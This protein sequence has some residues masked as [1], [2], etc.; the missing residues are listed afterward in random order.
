M[1]LT[2]P[3]GS[4]QTGDLI[5][6]AAAVGD[7]VNNALA[8]PTEG[9]YADVIGA[10]I[11]S[12]DTNDVNLN[13]F[14]KFHNGTDTTATFAAVGGTNASNVAVCMVFRGVAT[15]A[16]GGPFSTTAVQASGVD[17]SNADPGQIA[18]ATGDCVVIVGATGHTGGGTAT[19][20]NPTNYTTNAA[21]RAHN[22]TIDCLVGMGYR[23][24]GYANPENPGAFTAA[25]IGTA[26]N[27]AWAAVTMALKE[28]P[29]V[30]LADIELVRM[31]PMSAPY[32][33]K[34]RY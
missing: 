26:A 18:T 7:T 28:A 25:T 6:I 34:A 14:W 19:Y 13:V 29:P 2:L 16:Q 10:T 33:P 3:T 4:M 11:Y 24:S 9:S 1:T 27:N 20:T 31:A 22:D 32:N 8:A 21:V 15:V 30:T 12:N 17:T 5:L 23:L